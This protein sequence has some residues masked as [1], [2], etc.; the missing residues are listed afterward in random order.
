M[1]LDQV[2]VDEEDLKHIVIFH[3]ITPFLNLD[4][5]IKWLH[6]L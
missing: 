1:F 6:T 5:C 4:T 3:F 2:L